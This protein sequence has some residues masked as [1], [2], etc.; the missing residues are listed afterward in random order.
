MDYKQKLTPALATQMSKRQIDKHF[1][2]T[3]TLMAGFKLKRYTSGTMTFSL[4]YTAP[5]ARRLRYTMGN[6]PAMSVPTARKLAEQLYAQIKL[7]GDPQREKKP[8]QSSGLRIKLSKHYFLC[9]CLPHSPIKPIKTGANK[10]A[11][12]GTGTAEIVEFDTS[13][14]EIG[15]SESFPLAE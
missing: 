7:G 8:L 2:V 5:D 14:H 15:W 13:N 1:E 11:A 12:A 6:Y 9:F 3:D 4:I 10:K